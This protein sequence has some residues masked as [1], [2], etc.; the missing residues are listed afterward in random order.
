MTDVRIGEFKSPTNKT[1]FE[2]ALRV[3]RQLS[4]RIRN[5]ENENIGYIS[6]DLKLT[7]L[8]GSVK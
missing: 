2:C 1:V 4:R 8:P 3:I 7:L 6:R 5:V